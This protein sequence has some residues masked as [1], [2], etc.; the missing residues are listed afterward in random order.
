MIREDINLRV[1]D[2]PYLHQLWSLMPLA[3]GVGA[4]DLG[5]ELEIFTDVRHVPREALAV[6]LSPLVFLLAAKDTNQF[7]RAFLDVKVVLDP[8]W[9]I[10]NF[11]EVVNVGDTFPYHEYQAIRCLYP[12]IDRG[13]LVVSCVRDRLWRRRRY[14]FA[15]KS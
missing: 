6:L 13:F 1:V 12:R 9:L 11:L 3:G 14:G 5:S 10:L 7:V 8:H 2:H 4:K 15:S